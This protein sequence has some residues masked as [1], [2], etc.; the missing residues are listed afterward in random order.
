LV[1]VLFLELSPGVCHGGHVLGD[2]GELV[3]AILNGVAE[4]RDVHRDLLSVDEV[5]NSLGSGAD[6]VE[7]WL[8][9]LQIWSG[10]CAGLSR[11]RVGLSRQSGRGLRRTGWDV[12]LGWTLG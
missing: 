4:A 5:L 9:C 7:R 3:S 12:V 8:D 10:S 11:G 1:G 2:L 6:E